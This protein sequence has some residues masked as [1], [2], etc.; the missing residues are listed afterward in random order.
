MTSRNLYFKLMQ[1]DL[2]RRIWTAALTILGILFTLLVPVAVKC[3]E[4]AEY[5]ES[6]E[7]YMRSRMASDIVTYLGTSEILVYVLLFICVLWAVSG[8]SYLHNSRRVDFYHSLPVKR[9]VL[10]LVNYLDGIIVTAIVYLVIL[11]PSVLFAYRA[12]LTGA[13]I[14]LMPFQAFIV[15]MAYYCLIYTTVVIAMMLT[16]HIVVAIMGTGIILSYGPLV[17]SVVN[18]YFS[19]WFHTFYPTSATESLVNAFVRYTSPFTDYLYT[20]QDLIDYSAIPPDA[21]GAVIVTVI[22]AVAAYE[23]YKIRPSEAA[24]RALAFKKTEMPLKVLLVIPISLILGMFFYNVRPTLIWTVFG[25]VIGALLSHCI[26]EII[27]R[28]DFRRLFDH[29]ICLGVCGGTAILLSLAGYFDWY[30]YDR[31]IPDSSKVDSISVVTYDDYWVTFGHP[32]VQDDEDQSMYWNYWQYDLLEDYVF[33][34]MHLTEL[35]PAMDLSQKG[36]SYDELRRQDKEISGQYMKWFV[37]QYHMADGRDVTRQ[38]IVPMEDEEWS[39]WYAIYDDSQ[40]KEGLFPILSQTPQEAAHVNFQQFGSL[41]EV[42]IDDGERAKLFECYQ[43]ELKAQTMKER[44]EE[45]PVGL[46]QFMTEDHY[47]ASRQEYARYGY[48]AVGS[49]CLYPI[50]P[51]FTGTI[52]LLEDAGVEFM[53]LDK[54][55]ISEIWIEHYDPGI[56]SS[57]YVEEEEIEDFFAGKTMVY[58]G[59]ADIGILAPALCYYGFLQYD[60]YYEWTGADY[61]NVMAR[62]NVSA[63]DEI[64]GELYDKYYSFMINVDRLSS[65]DRVLYGLKSAYNEE[66]DEEEVDIID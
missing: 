15:N 53:E 2:K 6:W 8:F 4:Y 35:M 61:V 50:Y 46:I 48:S 36:I 59:D 42:E 57:G 63:D 5:A 31:W 18:G 54:D 60:P 47:K 20:M 58:D 24:G 23:I 51:S 29:K 39:D 43:E 45:F 44:E 14:G 56:Y 19:T 17:V 40:Y 52:S 41:R 7:D 13:E 38:Y 28:F 25:T 26:L 33:E 37:I 65:G 16:G 22:L 64:F 49:R 10:F 62:F 34:N 12:G 27:F 32:I 9:H 3:S 1:E 11:I 21:A 30:G 55:T 66:N